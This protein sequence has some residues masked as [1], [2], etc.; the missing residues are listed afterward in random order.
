MS[1]NTP[2]KHK[3][4]LVEFLAP[5]CVQVY[6][7]LLIIRQLFCSRQKNIGSCLLWCSSLRLPKCFYY[8]SSLIFDGLPAVLSLQGHK[9]SKQMR[10]GAKHNNHFCLWTQSTLASNYIQNW[11]WLVMSRRNRRTFK[12]FFQRFSNST[13]L[14]KQYKISPNTTHTNTQ[15]SLGRHSLSKKEKSFPLKVVAARFL[16]LHANPGRKSNIDDSLHTTH[17]HRPSY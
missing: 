9:E 7:I 16:S 2:F 15:W 8:V 14:R 6:Y 10:L 12:I 1:E 13:L 11:L 5:R 3:N 4:Q 17:T